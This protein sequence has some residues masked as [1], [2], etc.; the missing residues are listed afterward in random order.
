MERRDGVESRRRSGGR[1]Q[2]SGKRRRN[3]QP[4]DDIRVRIPRWG[5][6]KSFVRDEGGWRGRVVTR[7][8]K[9]RQDTVGR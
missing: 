1:G 4:V 9:A 3:G 2:A 6:K 7:T 5:D 8:C